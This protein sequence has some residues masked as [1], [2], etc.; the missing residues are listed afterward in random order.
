MSYSLHDFKTAQ[1]N[2]ML[3]DDG[4]A[5]SVTREPEYLILNLTSTLMVAHPQ[6]LSDQTSA[7][8]EKPVAL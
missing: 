2:R 1:P 6:L 8:L 5:V 3:H 4:W 7:A